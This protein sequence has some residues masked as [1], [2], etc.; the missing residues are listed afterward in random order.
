MFIV[1][2]MVCEEIIFRG[3]RVFLFGSRHSDNSGQLDLIKRSIEDFNPDIVLVEGNFDTATFNSAEDAIR[4][5]REQGY[6]SFISKERS[7]PLESN[8]PPHGNDR[9]FIE[10]KYDAETN[11]LYFLLRKFSP[12]TTNKEKERIKML[13]K[14]ILNENFDDSK[15]YSDYFNPALSINLFN[16]ITKELNVFRDEFMLNK[17]GDLLKRYSKIFIIKGDY[18]LNVNLEN[19]REIVNDS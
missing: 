16:R 10:D 6:A 17:I 15:N 9:K 7:I 4:Y 5:G 18:H 13:L 3:K 11:E 19:I 14:K 1:N 2:E 8:D 12:K